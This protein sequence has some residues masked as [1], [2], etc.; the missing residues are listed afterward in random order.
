MV[1]ETWLVALSSEAVPGL[2]RWQQ[3]AAFAVGGLGLLCSLKW[4]RPQQVQQ[5]LILVRRNSPG[6]CVLA[7]AA[8]AGLTAGRAARLLLERPEGSAITVPSRS[9]F[10]TGQYNFLPLNVG[11]EAEALE[12]SYDCT[13]LE[14]QADGRIFDVNEWRLE[15]GNH[16]WLLSEPSGELTRRAGAGRSFL[17]NR[18]GTVSPQQ[19]PEL[20]L[21]A[22]RPGP[23]HGLLY[24][25][26]PAAT[27][28][29]GCLLVTASLTAAW[30][31]EGKLELSAMTGADAVAPSARLPS[32]ALLASRVLSFAGCCFAVAKAVLGFRSVAGSGGASLPLG[33]CEVLATFTIWT[34]V[35]MGLYWLQTS[36]L[37]GAHL[38]TG[39]APPDAYA[40]VLW[41]CFE[42][43]YA[44]AWMVFLVCW[45]VLIPRMKLVGAK[46][47]LRLMLSGVVL[48]QHNANLLLMQAELVSSRWTFCGYHSIFC[49][50][51]GFI[52]VVFN[53][54]VHATTGHWIYFFLD[55]E[56]PAVIPSLMALK[57][58][59]LGFFRIG[60][61]CASLLGRP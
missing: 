44:M 8:V 16:L 12:A 39:W 55:Y 48:F 54:W 57:L 21:G 37:T 22:R 35:L 30:Y 6:R 52:Y 9:G 27:Y 26:W 40:A 36:A 24:G 53:W 14:R 43:L 38:L 42:I 3:V 5:R 47:G 50:Q 59:I 46:A 51:F 32:V 17:V 4:L 23:L 28:M 20:A 11:P 25:F 29:L 41:V 7:P 13:F 33:G 1:L 10:Q 60:E 15:R 18:D 2:P 45:L 58:A 34:W 49:V 61:H 56:R 19:R 31:H